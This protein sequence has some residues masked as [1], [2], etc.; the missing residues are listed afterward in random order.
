MTYQPQRDGVRLGGLIRCCLETIGT[1]YPP[2]GPMR[3]ATEGQQLQCKHVDTPNHRM[4]FHDG[5]WEWDR[6]AAGLPPEPQDATDA[7]C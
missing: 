6:D 4:V 2:D 7:D 5:A 1:L 3:V